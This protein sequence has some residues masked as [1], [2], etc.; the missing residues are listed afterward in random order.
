MLWQP[1]WNIYTENLFT[2]SLVC[3]SFL[4]HST[5][6]QYCATAVISSYFTHPW[7]VHCVCLQTWHCTTAV[8]CGYLRSPKCHHWPISSHFIQSYPH[9]TSSVTSNEYNANLYYCHDVFV[10]FLPFFL[11]LICKPSATWVK[12][13][14]VTAGAV[15]D[16][17]MDIDIVPEPGGLIIQSTAGA[18]PITNK[19]GTVSM[20]VTA[21]K[22]GRTVC[23]TA[24]FN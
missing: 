2:V 9:K 16:P 4:F 6:A 11:A 18:I 5:Y 10:T 20:K 15:W 12:L 19:K 14:W 21:M 7:H 23:S 24:V 22:E 8:H 13:L 1:Y 17:I 3:L